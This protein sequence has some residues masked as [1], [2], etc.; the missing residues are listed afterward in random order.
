M[1]HRVVVIGVGNG[2]RGDD[3][4]GLEV[5]RRLAD[6]NGQSGIAVLAHEGEGV[7]L[8]ELWAGA[9]AVVLVDS[10]RSGAAPGTIVRID[11]CAAPVL[12]PLQRTSSHAT[13]VAQ[14]IEFA[15]I[16]GRLPATVIV[17]GIE[18]AAYSLGSALSEP[19]RVAVVA[20]ARAVR[21]EALTLVRDAAEPAIR[22]RPIESAHS[23]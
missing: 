9:G 13:G 22:E 14:A 15:R 18:G 20:A 3:A 16:L 12:V 23:Y 11:A 7:T 17:Y 10:V 8:L 4:V 21:D 5:A 6:L 1:P 19:V 2:M